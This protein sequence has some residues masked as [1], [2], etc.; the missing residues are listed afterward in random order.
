M[1]IKLSILMSTYNSARYI[2]DA[3]KSIL[4]QTYREFELLIID[5]GS[6]DDTERKIKEFSDK[7]IR[8]E[9]IAH[10]GRSAALNLGLNLCACE[11]VALMDADDICHSQRLE[12][13]INSLVFEE[14][15]ISCTWSLYF[16]KG[17]IRYSRETPVD[18]Y[19]LNKKMA[20]HNYIDNPSVV[21]NKK[22]ILANGGYNTNYKVHEDYE[23]WLRIKN[24][25]RFIVVPEYLIYMRMQKNSLSRAEKE[26]PQIVYAIQKPY[27][28]N[29]NES[30]GIDNKEEKRTLKGWREYFYGDK[31]ATRNYWSIKDFFRDYK[32]LAAYL[33]TF[34][35]VNVF[36]KIRN[37]RVRMRLG[38]S[39]RLRYRL[40][41]Y[42][43]K[44]EL[45]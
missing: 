20:L 26:S 12:K 42:Y 14:N 7:R 23:L 39:T 44:N 21:Y 13:Q 36:V 6:D 37:S 29:L 25:A 15:S 45:E 33:F 4:G 22:F 16:S 27:Y 5:D 9:K 1:N 34:M 40:R 43:E 28:D 2:S 41:N 30:F 31:D 11:W 24:K 38:L 35:P 19:E 17:K 8:Y 3:V 32:I 10:I 18:T